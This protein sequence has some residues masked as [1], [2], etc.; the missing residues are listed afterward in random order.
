MFKQ[1]SHPVTTQGVM[2]HFNFFRTGSKLGISPLMLAAMNGHVAAV[3]LLRDRGSDV[4]AQVGDRPLS[5]HQ[6]VFI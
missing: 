2:S 4:N 1:F 3:K 6:F 5:S